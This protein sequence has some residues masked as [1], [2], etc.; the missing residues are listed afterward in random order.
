MNEYTNYVSH[1]KLIIQFHR[2]QKGKENNVYYCVVYMYTHM[3]NLPKRRIH[4][5]NNNI[6]PVKASERNN[7]IISG[8]RARLLQV[9]H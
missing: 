9:H 2:D 3:T 1:K 6:E 5:M 4:L 8:V 7:G